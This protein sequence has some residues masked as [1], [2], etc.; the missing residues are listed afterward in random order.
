VT[1]E[2]VTP[3]VDVEVNLQ[4]APRDWMGTFLIGQA[5]VVEHQDPELADAYEAAAGEFYRALDGE[6]TAE[7]V[8]AEARDQ[9][10][11]AN[12]TAIFGL[13]AGLVVAFFGA[14]LGIL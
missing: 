9:R 1:N 11:R 12:L 4:D 14:F 8:L 7:A 2:T 3:M 6:D 13:S 5:A 10:H